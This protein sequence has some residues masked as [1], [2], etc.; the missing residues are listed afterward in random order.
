MKR[1]LKGRGRYY[2]G[3]L[4]S[5]LLVMIFAAAEAVLVFGLINYREHEA[6]ALV[7]YFAVLIALAI[8]AFK[9]GKCIFDFIERK[10]SSVC[11]T[12]KSAY[13]WAVAIEFAVYF[14]VL[15]IMTAIPPIIA[16]LSDGGAVEVSES[17][18]GWD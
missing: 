14:A 2:P 8:A 17:I 4:Y 6:A 12:D 1:T 5:I 7:L 11:K 3:G 9:L 10:L 16:K 15:I 18:N 13:G